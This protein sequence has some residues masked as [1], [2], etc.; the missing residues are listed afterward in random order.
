[1]EPT[2]VL[3]ASAKTT[4][5]PTV[6]AGNAFLCD[7]GQGTYKPNIKYHKSYNAVHKS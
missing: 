7:M 1:M 3:W 4:V 2:Q 6:T 5:L